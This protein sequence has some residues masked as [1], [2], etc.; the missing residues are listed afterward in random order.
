MTTKQNSWTNLTKKMK[1][2]NILEDD[3]LEKFIRS[4]GKGGQKVNKSDSCVYI[5]HLP[6]KI[7]VKCQETRSREN[8]RYH[9]RL[10]L[11]KIIE[12]QRLKEKDLRK[13]AL[14]KTTQQNKKRSKKSKRKMLENKSHQSKV[15]KMRQKPML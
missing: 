9:A 3:I 8:N 7:E 11:V 14:Y 12:S 15:K 5:K 4:S 2:L 1:A 10:R 13:Q 6:S